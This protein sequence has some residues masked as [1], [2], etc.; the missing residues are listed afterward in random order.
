MSNRIFLAFLLIFGACNMDHQLGLV[1]LDSGTVSPVSNPITSSPDANANLQAH[2][3]VQ[4]IATSEAG[5]TA[6]TESISRP[7]AMAIGQLG[8]SQ[9]WTGYVENYQFSSGSDVIRFTFAADSAG[10]IIGTVLL[11]NAVPPPAATDPNIGY[12]SDFAATQVD[13][14]SYWV[15]GFSYSMANGKLTPDR[16]RFTARGNELWSGW[17]MLQTSVDSS[18]MCLPSWGPLPSWANHGQCAQVNPANGQTIDVDCGKLALCIE[19]PVCICSATTCS[20]DLSTGG[21]VSFDL[22]LSGTAA[23]GSI[24]GNLGQYN[25]HFT[26]DP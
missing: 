13:V 5:A 26:Q 2:A 14:S 18:G 10:Q 11:G 3:D 20:V 7:D 17:C 25:V 12:P 8:S 24:V 19:S 9:S 16:V 21:T 22:A 4:G 1:G 15:E 23:N 6:Q